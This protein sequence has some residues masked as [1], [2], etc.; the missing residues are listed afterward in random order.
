MNRRAAMY[1][2][3]KVSYPSHWDELADEALIKLYQETGDQLIICF[4]M[5]RHKTPIVAISFRFLRNR[6]AVEDFVHDLYLRLVDKLRKAEVRK[7]S[8][9]LS[10]MVKNKHKD[11]LGKHDVRVNYEIRVQNNKDPFYQN[12][13]DFDMDN[14]L[15]E[16]RLK[17]YFEQGVLSRMEYNCLKDR[18]Q[19]MKPA[20]IAESLDPQILGLF[21]Q[22]GQ[23]T[24]EE[25][26]KLKKKKVFG[27]LER[28]YK[29]MKETLGE[30]FTGYFQ[31]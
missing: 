11:D 4:L 3:E 31:T 24:C 13:W 19:G 6:E 30:D 21:P 5:N 29:K 20:E 16:E 15:S 7:F 25:F 10:T 12:S 1:F 28:S 2:F 8:A 23:K 9:F 22:E 27:A 17:G 18:S 26:I 14:P